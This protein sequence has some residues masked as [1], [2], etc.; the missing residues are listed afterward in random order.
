MKTILEIDGKRYKAVPDEPG[1]NSCAA[2]G[3]ALWDMCSPSEIL[4]EDFIEDRCVH[5]EEDDS[6]TQA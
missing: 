5:F 4:C 2:N 6:T 1:V 3:C